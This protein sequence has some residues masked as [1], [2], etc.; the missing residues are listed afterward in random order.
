MIKLSKAFQIMEDDW[1]YELGKFLNEKYDY[2]VRTD[3]NKIII[4]K[5][6][7]PYVQLTVKLVVS[8]E[9]NTADKNFLVRQI[10]RSVSHG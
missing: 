2:P 4:G 10:D 6:T 9:E 5:T 7:R 8:K 3:K 1:I